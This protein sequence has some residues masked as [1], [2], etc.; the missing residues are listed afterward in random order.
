MGTHMA[1]V[2]PGASPT[3]SDQALHR[4]MMIQSTGG[5]EYSPGEKSF[6]NEIE[7]QLKLPVVSLGLSYFRRVKNS[8]VSLGFLSYVTNPA[9]PLTGFG[10]GMVLRGSGRLGER[11]V[12]APTFTLGSSWVDLNL[13]FAGR[14]STRVWWHAVVGSRWSPRDVPIYASGGVHIL[15][16][17]RI[18]VQCMLGL[19]YTIISYNLERFDYT[20][21]SPHNGWIPDDQLD[22]YSGKIWTPTLSVGPVFSF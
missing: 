15:A 6:D 7:G 17:Q 8:K 21:V 22:D 16:N 2:P 14:I 13:A 11:A 18:G 12:V 20:E 1:P 4:R 5:L 19:R 10:A 9:L 3:A